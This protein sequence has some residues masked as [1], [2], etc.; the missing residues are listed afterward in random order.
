[1]F[2]PTRGKRGPTVFPHTGSSRVSGKAKQPHC[3]TNSSHGQLLAFSSKQRC[4]SPKRDAATGI[5]EL[6][7]TGGLRS[8]PRS[9]LSILLAGLILDS[10]VCRSL[11]SSW[12][13]FH[14]SAGLPHKVSALFVMLRSQGVQ[15][16]RSSWS[17]PGLQSHFPTFLGFV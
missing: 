3:I 14:K 17:V 10:F 2:E 13:G 7:C 16:T 11:F 9:R 1:M 6:C 4:T 12:E 8:L 5:S 15:E